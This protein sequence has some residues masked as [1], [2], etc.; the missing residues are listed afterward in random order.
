VTEIPEA[1]IRYVAVRDQERNE[2][3]SGVMRTLTETELTL[4]KE[5]AVMGYVRGKLASRDAPVPPDSDI[6]RLV[7]A[8]CLDMPDLYPT[9]AA[10]GEHP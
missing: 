2:R 8:A 6:L 9:I 4:I 3:V 7:V 10:R 1:L 5:A